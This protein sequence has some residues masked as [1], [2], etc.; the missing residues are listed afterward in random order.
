MATSVALSKK[1]KALLRN[2]KLASK[3]VDAI[4]KQKQKLDNGE[5]IRITDDLSV[6][7]VSTTSASTESKK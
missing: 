4:L 3:V 6:Q 1:G 5:P 2:K 7:L